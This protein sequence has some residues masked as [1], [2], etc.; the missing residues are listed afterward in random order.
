MARRRRRPARRSC[1]VDPSR[2]RALLAVLAGTVLLAL[3]AAGLILFK[4]I[5]RA[6]G[7]E[8]VQPVPSTLPRP[9][10][11][12]LNSVNPNQP[13]INVE[14]EAAGQGGAQMAKDGAD[15]KL[16]WR[17]AV[18][19]ED[20]PQVVGYKIFFL[21]LLLVLLLLI[22]LSVYAWAS[23]PKYEEVQGLVNAANQ[24]A[25]QAAK[26]Q[27]AASAQK[28]TASTIEVDYT[29]AAVNPAAAWEQARS[30]WL[31]HLKDLGQL[32]L[33]TPVFP[34]MGAVIGYIFGDRRSQESKDT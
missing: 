31:T 22:L 25:V 30:D 26:Q 27:P 28:P 3:L 9:H 7:R 11:P 4:N 5:R 34:L 19:A 24:S 13:S 21:L 16:G 18:K 29:V 12:P 6:I 14:A 8:H 23:Y 32:F 20:T 15:A 2:R 10:R 33:L 1:G 17:P